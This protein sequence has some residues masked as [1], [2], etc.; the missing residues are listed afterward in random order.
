M[1]S[2]FAVQVDRLTSSLLPDKSSLLLP[3]TSPVPSTAPIKRR[4][5]GSDLDLNPS[6]NCVPM[7]GIEP[8]DS[9]TAITSELSRNSPTSTA[10]YVSSLNIPEVTTNPQLNNEAVAM[11]TH[12]A[13]ALNAAEKSIATKDNNSRECS[14]ARFSSNEAQHIDNQSAQDS[15]SQV[16]RIRGFG[17][18]FDDDDLD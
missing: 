7:D 6:D 10:N 11:E 3:D 9:S 15:R 8:L 13:M 1:T 16:K 2:K 14:P 4:K 18:L 5:M 17:Y 12:A